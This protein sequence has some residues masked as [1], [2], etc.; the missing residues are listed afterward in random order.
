MQSTKMIFLMLMPK[1]HGG[2]KLMVEAW[3]DGP[4]VAL[5]FQ[6]VVRWAWVVHLV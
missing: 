1:G 5:F 3:R 6:K 4:L 2:P